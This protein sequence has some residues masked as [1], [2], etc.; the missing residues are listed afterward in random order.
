[1]LS[2]VKH[3]MFVCVRNS[4]WRSVY[5]AA[6]SKEEGA[7]L[8]AQ[9]VASALLKKGYAIDHPCHGIETVILDFRTNGQL[10]EILK[11]ECGGISSRAAPN[12]PGG[13]SN[14]RRF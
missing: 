8:L 5:F 9:S 12:N 2:S 6:G 11:V 1:M 4:F 14:V 10:R 7:D 3:V 13:A